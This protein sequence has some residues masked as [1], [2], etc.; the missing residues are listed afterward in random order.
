[1]KKGGKLVA[2]HLKKKANPTVCGEA[3][4]GLRLGGLKRIRGI[5]LKRTKKRERTV[6]RPYGGCLSS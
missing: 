4:R 2:I 5:A 3:G 6:S 1:M